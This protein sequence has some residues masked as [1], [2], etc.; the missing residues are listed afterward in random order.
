MSASGTWHRRR[1]EL[2]ANLALLIAYALLALLFFTRRS[3]VPRVFIALA[4]AAAGVAL[5]DAVLIAMIPATAKNVTPK[6]VAELARTGIAAALWIAYFL[7]SERVRTTFVRTLEKRPL[8]APSVP[9]WAV[10]DG[11]AA[12]G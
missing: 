10:P 5:L 3:S 1:F 11:G 2:V 4:G 8:P 9:T 12:G 7:R 6:D